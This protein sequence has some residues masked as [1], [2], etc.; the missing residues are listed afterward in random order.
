MA[1]R[2]RPRHRETRLVKSTLEKHVTILLS[3]Q[4]LNKISNSCFIQIYWYVWP[5]S[6][7]KICYFGLNLFFLC[8]TRN[9][10]YHH[11]I[12][13]QSLSANFRS[14]M[15]GLCWLYGHAR[16]PVCFSYGL[17][18]LYLFTYL[19]TYTTKEQYC[20]TVLVIAVT[21]LI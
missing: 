5:C 11:P 1:F 8:H 3:H 6:L 20:I 4:L 21:Q 15:L 10:Y 9:I 12:Y 7:F 18:A 16:I 14:C 17:S 19:F 2:L 13:R